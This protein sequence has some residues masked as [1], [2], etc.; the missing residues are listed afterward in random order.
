MDT[1]LLH[2]HGVHEDGAA[3]EAAALQA[4]R[5]CI[6]GAWAEEWMNGTIDVS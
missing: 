6:G 1:N 4:H 5:N 2:Q 3:E